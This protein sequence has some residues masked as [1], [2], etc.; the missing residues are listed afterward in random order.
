MRQ[1]INIVE[2]HQA[3]QKY[4][5]TMSV[6]KIGEE[7]SALIGVTVSAVNEE[8]AKSL[9]VDKI[10]Q[11]YSFPKEIVITDIQLAGDE[12]AIKMPAPRKRTPRP[13]KIKPVIV[14]KTRLKGGRSIYPT[15]TGE[16]WIEKGDPFLIDIS[17][18]DLHPDGLGTA[19]SAFF[20]NDKAGTETQ[21]TD[22]PISVTMVDGQYH[23]L[24]GY[25]RVV[26]AHRHGHSQVLCQEFI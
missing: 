6:T 26:K 13:K 4:S 19:Y 23:V 24:D 22:K 9:A 3:S 14:N 12:P 8:Q 18:L 21:T 11:R 5:V 2:S 17:D 15:P 20:W 7:G 10:D 1:F 25:H 16:R